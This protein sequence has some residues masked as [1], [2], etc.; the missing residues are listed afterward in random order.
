MPKCSKCKKD[1][2]TQQKLEEHKKKKV[3]CDFKCPRCPFQATSRQ[4]YWRHGKSGCIQLELSDES[5]AI[6]LAK[7]EY[8]IPITDITDPDLLKQA[9]DFATAND[10][11]VVIEETII[12]RKITVKGKNWRDDQ[13]AR[14]LRV[15]ENIRDDDVN[16]ALQC[17]EKQEAHELVPFVIDNLTQ[18]HGDYD[19]KDLHSIK[20]TDRSRKNVKICTRQDDEPRWLKLP[21]LEALSQVSAHSSKLLSSFLNEII[22]KLSKCVQKTGQTVRP[23]L[24]LFDPA[25]I[26]DPSYEA[27]GFIV[28][29]EEGDPLMAMFTDGPIPPVLKVSYEHRIKYCTMDSKILDALYETVQ[30]RK[31]EIVELLKELVLT[32]QDLTPFLQRTSAFI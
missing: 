4:Q 14:I 23:C 13:Q 17:L 10:C 21:R 8:P 12:K 22:P 30:Q 15:T 6:V 9:V 19:R 29:Q 26:D 11:E 28:Y 2:A 25:K 32:E 31:D 16:R 24:A 20:L 7:E 1:F 5:E 27:S 18:I 3:P